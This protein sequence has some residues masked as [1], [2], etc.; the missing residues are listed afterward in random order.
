MR[1]QNHPGDLTDA[2]WGLIQSQIP[3]HRGGRPRKVDPRD[4]VDA[5]FYILRT[6]CRWRDLPKDFSPKS[7]GWRYFDEWRHDGTLDKIHDRL[8]RE[9]RVVEKPYHP[10]TSASVD[11]RSVDATSGGECRGRDNAKDVDVDGRKRHIVVDSLGLPPAVLVTAVDVDDAK[12]AAELFAR[13]DGRPMSK[14]TRMYADGKYHNFNLYE[15]VEGDADWELT[16]VRRP[17]GAKGWVKLPIRWTVERTADVR[18]AGQVSSP[19]PRIGR[20]AR[21]C[22]RRNRS[23]SWR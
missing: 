4:V 5:L 19:E 21:A 6:G 10:R 14:V 13:L 18:L 3:V 20:R 15:R 17:E 22:C 2:Q 1:T 11:S 7:T 8:R 16:I 23:S 9:V 12:A